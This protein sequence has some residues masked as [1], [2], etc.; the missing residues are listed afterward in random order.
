MWWVRFEICARGVDRFGADKVFRGLALVD[1]SPNE[2]EGLRERGE[3]AW[4]ATYEV[5]LERPETL[6]ELRDYLGHWPPVLALEEITAFL[7]RLPGPGERRLLREPEHKSQEV[8][9][10]DP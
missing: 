3:E 7:Y 4:V 8:E 1:L 2:A 5:V 6:Q 10:D 9:D